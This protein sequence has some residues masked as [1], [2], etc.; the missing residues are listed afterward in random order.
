V[1]STIRP[2]ASAAGVE[3]T[4]NPVRDCWVCG[5]T[6]F[7]RLHEA[8]L[9]FTNF[10]EQDP[11]L[12]GYSGRTV[13]FQRCEACGFAQPEALPA[14]LHFFERIYDLRWAEEW[15]A[16]EFGSPY[17]DLIFATVLRG[18][19]RRLAPGHRRLL[20]VGAHVGR[21]I[22]M[23]GQSGW[24][25]EGVELNPRTAAF[26][27]RRSG[28]P[29]HQI[30]ARQLA[31]EHRL[32]SAVT[33]IDVLEHIPEPL[34]VLRSLGR[35]IEPGGWLV[36]KVPCGPSQL[37]K[38]RLVSVLRR[39]RHPNVATNLVHVSHFDAPS[40]CRA[41]EASGFTNIDL[42]VGAPELPPRRSRLRVW[43]TRLTRLGCYHLARAIPG[44]VS[45]PF[46]FNLQAFA[47]KPT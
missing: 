39:R 7:R 17:K 40:L 34:V 41:L 10:A 19:E 14:L 3:P 15:M 25:S 2:P 12:H 21:L 26:A 47:R 8:P 16:E 38:E 13:W 24:V 30:N 1:S 42:T 44:G 6:D 36:V 23:A 9:D 11:E 4:F 22:H 43:G 20:D 18:L 32:Y 31:D 28:R 46:A 29:V 33:L 27:A 35:L 37:L 45:T 5:G